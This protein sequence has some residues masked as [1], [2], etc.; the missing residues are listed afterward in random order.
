[1]DGDRTSQLA[2]SGGRPSTDAQRHRDPQ[3]GRDHR[4]YDFLG[5]ANTD[6]QARANTASAEARAS[7]RVL[8]NLV[9]SLR[10]EIDDT[11]AALKILDDASAQLWDG[12]AAVVDAGSE[13][14]TPPSTRLVDA[15]AGG[16]RT[17]L[18]RLSSRVSA[19]TSG[20]QITHRLGIL[21]LWGA[22]DGVYLLTGFTARRQFI[23]NE[24]ARSGAHKPSMEPSR[25]SMPLMLGSRS[26]DTRPSHGR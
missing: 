26:R 5:T 11:T 22:A 10:S 4:P 24:S 19:H 3:P 6:A 7:L 20:H 14:S 9:P 25:R 17:E 1:M 13:S 21:G 16:L 8:G 12:H 23:S 15:A 2:C 18:E